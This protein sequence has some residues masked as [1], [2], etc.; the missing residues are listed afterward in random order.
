MAFQLF[1]DEE[2]NALQLFQAGCWW[3]KDHRH[4]GQGTV[5]FTY[6]VRCD[7]PFE[8]GKVKEL[9]ITKAFSQTSEVL[10]N[11]LPLCTPNATH[12]FSARGGWHVQV[13]FFYSDGLRPREPVPQPRLPTAAELLP[14][15]DPPL[16]PPGFC[17]PS[18]W[19]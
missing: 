10:R 15:E 1:S 17:V 13:T 7:K 18:L 19:E 3:T 16:P 6:R 2:W 12:F 5:V 8:L 4:R 11:G 14:L 9:A